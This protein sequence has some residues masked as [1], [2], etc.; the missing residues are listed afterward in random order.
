[1]Y[2]PYSWI[3]IDLQK[4]FPPPDVSRE[5]QAGFA[6]SARRSLDGDRIA[7]QTQLHSPPA[8]LRQ[9]GA[10][11]DCPILRVGAAGRLSR[12]ASDKPRRG[13]RCVR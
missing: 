10:A 2:G 3:S 7:R 8:T 6:I 13:V 1:M 11:I 4:A 5:G 9:T 12:T